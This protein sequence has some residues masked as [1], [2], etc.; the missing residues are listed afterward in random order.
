MTIAAR[1]NFDLLIARVGERYMTD[2]GF[3]QKPPA[4]AP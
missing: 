4:C 2:C 3:M 1:R